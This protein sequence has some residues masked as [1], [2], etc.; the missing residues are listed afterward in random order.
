[1]MPVNGTGM[2]RVLLVND[3]S[4]FGKC[5]LSVALPIVSSYGC[6]AVALPT[7]VLSTHTGGFE[8]Y[9]LQDMTDSMERFAAHWKAL[10]LHFDA[11]STGFFGSAKQ[12]G[13]AERLIRDFAG[14]QTPVIVDPV[15][16]DS[17]SLYPCFQEEMVG[18]MRELCTRATVITPNHTEAC[19]LTGRP[20]GTPAE[21]LIGLLDAP[22]VI[23][24]GVRQGDR[25]GY[26]ARCGDR[27]CTVFKPYADHTLH[28]TGDVFVSALC[29]ELLRQEDPLRALQGAADFCDACIRATE[30]R[31]PSHWYGLAFEDV[32]AA[33]KEE[34]I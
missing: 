34:T 5:S 30:R 29:G 16:G 19:L 11:V 25:I 27:S 4:C 22:F 13:T 7:A 1:M 24:T 10:G 6:E 17:G 32:L 2:K 3:L 21:E 9:V 20:M 28:G 14:A 23:I 15:L 18:A 31:Q 12:V 8:G 33:R 26:A